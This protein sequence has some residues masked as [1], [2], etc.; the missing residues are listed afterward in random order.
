[1]VASNAE[2]LIVL[3]GKALVALVAAATA[4]SKLGDILTKRRGDRR[5]W[6]REDFEAVIDSMKE[7]NARCWAENDRLRSEMAAGFARRD[8]EIRR[9]EQRL[10]HRRDENHWLNNKLAGYVLEYGDLPMAD[11][12][13]EPPN[14]DEDPPTLLREDA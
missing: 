11:P 6:E 4:T 5:Q 3:V 14:S 13:P 1:M 2:E 7:E 9:L 8:T 12:R 10:N